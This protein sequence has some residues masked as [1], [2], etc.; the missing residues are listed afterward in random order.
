[1]ARGYAEGVNRYLSDTGLANL[2]AECRNASWV[3]AITADDLY[4]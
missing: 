1:M 3:R 2:P 4:L